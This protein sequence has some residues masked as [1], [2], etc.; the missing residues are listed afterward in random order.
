MVLL[1]DGTDPCMLFISQMINTCTGASKTVHASLAQAI[2]TGE[3]LK[4][5]KMSVA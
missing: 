5:Q 4:S 2:V 3:Q 1:G